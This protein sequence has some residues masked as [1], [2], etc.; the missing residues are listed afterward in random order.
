MPPAPL[1][2]GEAGALAPRRLSSAPAGPTWAWYALGVACIALGLLELAAYGARAAIL[3]ESTW[4][5]LGGVASLKRVAVFLGSGWAGGTAAWLAPRLWLAQGLVLAAAAAWLAGRAVVDD[6]RHRRWL[7]SA[8]LLA[9]LVPAFWGIG[10][11]STVTIH[12]EATQ[13]VA[14]GLENLGRSDLGYV[15][16]GFIHYPSRQYLL[17]ALPARVLGRTV[18]ALR[19]GFAL[20]FTLAAL[21]LFA[22]LHAWLRQRGAE[23][24][25]AGITVLAVPAFPF[26]FRFLRAFE[27]SMLPMCLAMAAVGL[28]L[29]CHLRLTPWRLAA[30]TWVG[31]LLGASYTPSLATWGLLLATLA[32]ATVLAFPSH[33]PAVLALAAS[34]GLVLLVGVASFLTRGDGPLTA[35]DALTASTTWCGLSAVLLGRPEPFA[36]WLLQLPFDAFLALALVGRLGWVS[37]AVAAWAVV[38]VVAASNLKGYAAPSPPFALHR[39]LVIVPP[40]LALMLHHVL[41]WLA[42]V[43]PAARTWAC[44]L[45]ALL[46][47]GSV[48]VPALAGA[49]RIVP[50]AAQAL[51]LDLQTA[52]SEH[53]LSSLAR[54][55][56]VVLQNHER[57]GDLKSYLTYF[58]PGSPLVHR[59]SASVHTVELGQGAAF[60]VDEALWP[61]VAPALPAGLASVTSLPAEGGPVR[62]HRLVIPPGTPGRWTLPELPGELVGTLDPCPGGGAQAL[63]LT[64][65]MPR[66]LVNEVTPMRLNLSAGDEP[67]AIAGVRY[68]R[69]L[70]THAPWRATYDVPAGVCGLRALV[71]L[72]DRDSC[73]GLVAAVAVIDASGKELLPPT[74][75]RAGEAFPIELQLGGTTRVTLLSLDGGDGIDCD[76]VSWIDPAFTPCE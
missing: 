71:G 42:R 28:V 21:T 23:P 38:V 35:G 58:F 37:G 27:Q 73:P 15:E 2:G 25:L 20:V 33:R 54:P 74:T 12:H 57:Y 53:G 69:G 9:A 29:L 45:L 60:Y 64:C 63:P 1:V 47:A 16:S 8:C 10:G 48:L 36:P 39:A 66:Q 7:G 44:R 34:A 32:V 6:L 41:P 50:G 70:G 4:P 55:A 30:L 56:I 62:Q 65:L 18:L 46:L 75:V 59:L 68:P 52:A 19:L 22:A 3:S 76:H 17:L 61:L 14:L 24:A 31:G 26:A 72:Q 40:L 5:F 49:Y 67:L 13:Q 51:I 43:R 11:T